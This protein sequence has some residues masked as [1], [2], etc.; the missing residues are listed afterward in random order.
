M[1][2]QPHY[3]SFNSDHFP[4]LIGTQL[5]TYQSNPP[6]SWNIKTADWTSFNK[7]ISLTETFLSPT[8]SC[9]AITEQIKQHAN[10]HIGKSVN[11]NNRRTALYWNQDC[12]AAKK[13]KNKALN[14]YRN[15]K[16]NLTLAYGLHIKKQ[17]LSINTQ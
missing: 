15:H 14:K 7:D 6:S 2:W 12:S 1:H 8:Q 17:M 3:D 10:Q 16:G 5:D 13:E 9:G 11:S 4:I